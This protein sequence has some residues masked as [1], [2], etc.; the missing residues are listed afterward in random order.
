MRESASFLNKSNREVTE[1]L[2]NLLKVHL[3]TEL[4]A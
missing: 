2:M 3:K 4:S 1:M